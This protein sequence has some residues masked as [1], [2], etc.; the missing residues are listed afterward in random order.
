M[1]FT[2]EQAEEIKKQLLAQVEKMPNENKESVKTYIEGLDEEGLEDFLKQNN[3]RVGEAGLEQG[4]ASSETKEQ[5]CIFCQIVQNEIPSFKIAE[6]KKAIAILEI[7]PLSKGH[8]IILPKEHITIEKM[9]KSALS[10]AQKLAKKIKKKLKPE[11]VK[12]E[13]SSLMG[14]SMVNVI[15]LYKGIPAKKQKAEEEELKQMQRKLETKKRKPRKKEEQI[16]TP[17]TE[18]QKQERIKKEKIEISKL[19]KVPA[20]RIPR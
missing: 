1:A 2:S 5:K 14:H 19:P 20:F 16:K 13:S 15:P 12:I 8:V 6:L 18:E 9:P 3:I 10:L 4:E 17:E 7:N 11:E